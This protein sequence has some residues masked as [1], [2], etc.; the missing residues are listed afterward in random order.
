MGD[1]VLLRLENLDR[2]RSKSTYERAMVDDLAWLGLDWDAEYVQSD[3]LEYYDAALD[4]LAKDQLLY[5]CSCSRA[6][7]R[8]AGNRAP[9]GGFRYDNRCR[10]RRLPTRAEGGWR[11]SPNP[12]RA[13]LPEGFVS[14]VDLGGLDLGQDPVAAFGDPIVL[15]RDGAAAYH[16][17][18]VVDDA[19]SRVTRIVRG[20]D[21]MS[22]SATQVA[23]GTH[24]G[25]AALQYRHHMLLLERRGE[26]LAKLH[27]SVSITDLRE[28][29]SA[30]QLC[31]VLAFAAGL[32]ESPE[33]TTPSELVGEFSW[34]RVRSEDRIAI[35][36]GQRLEISEFSHQ[37][38]PR[39][40]GHSGQARDS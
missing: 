33:P 34:Q 2:E 27:G 21:L 23:L 6:Q 38:V 31:G 20:R 29:Y 19:A 15:R 10:G 22:N 8:E 39:L 7:I 1:R 16:L 37:F 35:W 24:L 3:R 18:C 13:R 4:Q 12:L 40:G 30:T 32:I 9:D 14:P 28:V 5:P 36:T 26:K 17:A 11:S 25:L